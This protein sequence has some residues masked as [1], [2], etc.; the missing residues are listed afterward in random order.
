MALVNDRGGWWGLQCPARQVGLSH[1]H[2]RGC[3]DHPGTVCCECGSVVGET[4]R[5]LA[6]GAAAVDVDARLV[7][8]GLEP[9]SDDTLMEPR[10]ISGQGPT[11]PT[12]ERGRGEL[13]FRDRI[14]LE[15][16]AFM[17]RRRG[18]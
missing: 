13:T 6:P 4:R 12:W 14:R 11:G 7:A 9:L 5:P 10:M 15:F 16:V 17:E 8:I 2:E 3:E 18:G 1:V